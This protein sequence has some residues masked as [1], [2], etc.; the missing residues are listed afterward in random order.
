MTQSRKLR[1]I[2]VTEAGR[3][4]LR[5]TKAAKG[6]TFEQI[7]KKAEVSLKTVKN[8]FGG[9]AVDP[10]NALAITKALE[11]TITDVVDPDDWKKVLGEAKPKPTSVAPN[12]G[13]VCREMLEEQKRLTSN[14]LMDYESAKF[15]R[16]QIHVPLALVQ[17]TKPAQRSGEFSPESGM[18]LY[19]PQYEEKQRFEYD[20]FLT[21]ILKQGEGKTDGKRIALIGEPGA[22]KTTLLQAI[23]FWMLEDN[24][25]LPIWISLADL[26]GKDIRTHLLDTWLKQAIPEP[27]LTQAIQD[28]FLVQV[29]QGRVWLLLD[30]LDEMTSDVNTRNFVSQQW[31]ASQLTG[32][33][34]RTR[35]VLT[36]RLNVWQ[37]NTNALE[38]FETYRLLNF[39]YPAQV[40]KF[41]NNWFQDTDS[42]KG[43]RLKTELDRPE[44]VRIRDLV[45]NPLRLALLCSTW[46][47]REGNLPDTKLGFY[48][49]FE[50]EFYIWKNAY[51]RTTLTQRRQL[52][53]ALGRLALLDIN[54]GPSRFRLRESWISE[55]LGDPEDEDSLFYQAMQLGWLNVVG[56][57]AENPDEKVYAFFHPTFQEYFAAL[58][59]E[60]WHF[61]FDHK[62]HDPEQGKYHIFEP[63]W[64]EVILLWLGRPHKEV[65]KEQKESFITALLDFNDECGGFYSQIAINLIAAGIGEIIDLNNIEE[66]T[67]EEIT[68]DVFYAAFMYVLRYL[69]LHICGFPDSNNLK[70][71]HI[72]NPARKIA[73]ENFKE[74]KSKFL[75]SY[76]SFLIIC[77]RDMQFEDIITDLSIYKKENNFELYDFISSYAAYFDVNE[78]SQM[79]IAY[80]HVTGIY[81]LEKSYFNILIYRRDCRHSLICEVASLLGEVD[82]A[83]QIAIDT[84]LEL[85]PKIENE[86]IGWQAIN[87]LEKIDPGNQIVVQEIE[88]IVSSK[89]NGDRFLVDK[90]SL[91]ALK[92]NK[93]IIRSLIQL[94]DKITDENTLLDIITILETIG[95]NDEDVFN[96]LIK[97]IQIKG[98][99]VRWCAG[100]AIYCL[101]KGKETEIEPLIQLTRSKD[102]STRLLAIFLLGYFSKLN[103]V[104]STVVDNAVNDIKNGDIRCLLNSILGKTNKGNDQTIILLIKLINKSKNEN[105]IR[106]A[107]LG[108]EAVVNGNEDA[109][110]CLINL[111]SDTKSVTTCKQA[112]NSLIKIY[113]VNPQKSVING[114]VKVLTEKKYAYNCEKVCE[115]LLKILHNQSLGLV[116]KSLSS[117]NFRF[118]HIA[119]IANI[120]FEIYET[121]PVGYTAVHKTLLYC[122]KNMSYPD[123]YKAWHHPIF[124]TTSKLANDTLFNYASTVKSLETQNTNICSQVQATF[125]TYPLCINAEALAGETD[126]GAITKGLCNRIFRQALPKEV[127]PKVDNI[128]EL[129]REIIALKQRLQKHNLALILNKCEPYPKLERLCRQ[130]ADELHIGWVTEAPLEPPLKGFM[131]NQPNLVSALQSW[132]KEIG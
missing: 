55:E 44:R 49:K 74:L 48:Q 121:Y 124:T 31:V 27:Q 88:K 83:N 86:E 118:S 11:M 19:E 16:E 105:I 75:V 106:L 97:L 56:V 79:L 58:A 122:S 35:V 100:S 81:K 119:N 45:K 24:L 25:G 47:R 17:Q 91:Q 129:E 9:E 36:C 104:S 64:K 52:N 62:P 15:E 109:I 96:T 80:F 41:I 50:Q 18:K 114:L 30:G 72:Y 67:P 112:A 12:W 33:I 4:R 32:W 116:V 10:D 38:A 21:Q 107:T 108:L 13:E 2:S 78:I 5:S 61:F 128:F 99:E 53:K 93:N 37:A 26:Q 77:L 14:A 3:E 7:E 110:I 34:A 68:N 76:L 40:Q 20:A 71:I 98:E 132:L 57:A 59:V 123:F 85:I 120:K 8:F 126:M 115:I 84:L 39:N 113:T 101:A 111:I 65:P 82:I 92:G 28:D 131:P 94:V 103:K 43:E 6:W 125:N 102:E 63:Q 23:A 130:L 29:E 90:N 60:D 87:T 42:A 73:I 22:G 70:W 54:S 89:K 1:G 66:L 95:E 127:P 69:F 46:Q 51:F 117:I